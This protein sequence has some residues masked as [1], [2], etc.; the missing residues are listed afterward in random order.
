MADSYVQ[1]QG[2][3]SATRFAVHEEVEK[4]MLPNTTLGSRFCEHACGFSVAASSCRWFETS[5]G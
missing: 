5:R 1:E 3:G 2:Y 4:P